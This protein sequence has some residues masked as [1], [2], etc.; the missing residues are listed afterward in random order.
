MAAVNEG[1]T[2]VKFFHAG[3][4][5]GLAAIKALSGPLQKMVLVPTGDVGAGILGEY[6]STGAVVAVG[7]TWMVAPP[8]VAAGDFGCV[9]RLTG[10]AIEAVEATEALPDGTPE[11]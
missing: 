5:G 10:E 4:S 1:I 8:L 3:T 9:T 11:T 7:G 2:V 6:L